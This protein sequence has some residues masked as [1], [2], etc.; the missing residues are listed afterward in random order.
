MLSMMRRRYSLLA[1]EEEEKVVYTDLAVEGAGVGD[2][3]L[4][5]VGIH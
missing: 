4:G 2:V 5:L 3:F 1:K